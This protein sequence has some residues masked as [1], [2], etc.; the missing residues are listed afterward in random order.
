MSMVCG[1]P[2]KGEGSGICGCM[3]TG[4]VKNLDFRFS[5][6]CHKLQKSPLTKLPLTKVIILIS[7]VQGYLLGRW[8]SCK[9]RSTNDW[10]H[11]HLLQTV[12]QHNKSCVCIFHQY[13]CFQLKV[14]CF[15][16]IDLLSAES[17]MHDPFDRFAR[18]VSHHSTDSL[19]NS[20]YRSINSPM[21]NFALQFSDLEG[22]RFQYRPLLG[23]NTQ[24]MVQS[25]T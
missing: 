6:G 21:T 7:T 12:E 20:S 5:C 19:M 23:L 22:V 10:V 15:F 11:L 3:W 8:S 16:I 4:E 1:C 13:F 17:M 2:L 25:S 9:Q 24:R 14:W 18:P